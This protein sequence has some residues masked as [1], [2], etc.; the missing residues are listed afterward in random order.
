MD[1][2]AAVFSHGGSSSHTP[3]F[4]NFIAL[5]TSLPLR[6]SVLTENSMFDAHL[7]A[8]LT[9]VE[10]K[11]VKKCTAGNGKMRMV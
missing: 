5:S 9:I 7:N 3:L 11:L 1:S 2:V 10:M 8:C 4:F 6:R